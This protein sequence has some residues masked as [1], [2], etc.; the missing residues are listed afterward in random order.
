MLQENKINL[1][2]F[3]EKIYSLICQ[4]GRELYKQILHDW[5]SELHKNRDRSIYRDKGKRKTV[6]KTVMGEVEYERHVYTYK[7][8]NGKSGTV[9][10]LDEAIGKPESGYFS[11]ALMLR[12][13]SAVC[14][15][16][17]RKAATEISALTGQCISHTA[18]W[19]VVQQLG[20]RID[21]IEE[22]NADK[23][24]LN[25][26]VGEIE[27]KLLFE[28]MDGIY[29]HLQGKAREEHGKGCE[30]KLAIAYD[31]FEET[32]K[33]EDKDK[34]SKKRFEL[35]N[36]VACANFENTI[37]FHR[38]REGVIAS[39]YNVDEI[40]IRVQNTDG[41]SWAKNDGADGVIHQLDPYH[42]NRAIV[43]ATS[44]ETY[45]KNMLELLYTK[46]IDLLLKYIEAL[47]IAEKDEKNKGAIESLHKYFSNNKE[48]L[49]SYKRRGIK[50]PA[51]PEGKE[52][53]NMGAMES[54]VFSIIGNRMKSRRK[55]WSIEGGNNLAR[56]LCLKATNKLDETL[57]K[58]ADVLPEKYAEEVIVGF[59]SAKTQVSVGKGYD[60]F[61]AI[62]IPTSQRWFKEIAK[63]KPIYS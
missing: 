14:E 32:R 36:K 27:S 40:E 15:M 20:E 19:N 46:E 38:R 24:S 8:E 44:N 3:E 7:D 28:E 4:Y 35:T 31:G 1:K 62:T 25:K 47:I 61:D 49:I 53:R 37:D 59:S 34:K 23:A 41:A 26:G 45:R 42:R 9:Y 17:Y 5:D 6:L 21:E 11:E 29:L 30:M 60:G 56:L 50:L 12:I 13:A 63:I 57:L 2:D 51:P 33:K 22:S 48:S 39:F 54:N 52:Y 58:I 55:C 10:L 18:A 16:P 43:R